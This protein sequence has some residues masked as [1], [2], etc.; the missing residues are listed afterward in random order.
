MHPATRE[1]IC[2]MILVIRQAL[3]SIE[4]ALSADE[5][6]AEDSKRAKVQRENSQVSG[7]ESQYLPEDA[8]DKIAAMF[9]LPTPEVNNGSSEPFSA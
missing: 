7:H 2:G 1:H 9:N 8:E 6:T 4:A 5:Y 3:N